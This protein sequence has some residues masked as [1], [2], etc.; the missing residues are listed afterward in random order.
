MYNDNSLSSKNLVTGSDNLEPVAD[1]P[2]LSDFLKEVNKL[3]S[4][5]KQA[6]FDYLEANKKWLDSLP[7]PV[8]EIEAKKREILNAYLVGAL[9]A[10]S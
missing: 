2:Y 7:A 3:P 8:S 1:Y 9:G 4:R 10:R 5:D 6:N